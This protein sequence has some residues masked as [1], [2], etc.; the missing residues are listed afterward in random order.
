[1]RLI[2]LR[3]TR[4]A[5]ANCSAE[6]RRSSGMSSK[7]MVTPASESRTRLR[8]AQ[9]R[10]QCRG[11]EPLRRRSRRAPVEVADHEQ[12]RWWGLN[13][14]LAND[15]EHAAVD[16]EVDRVAGGREER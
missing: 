9:E 4:R 7:S 13:T 5:A 11:I 3:A 12:D 14:R 15:V 6:P 8:R 2:G 16:L 10:P 1:M